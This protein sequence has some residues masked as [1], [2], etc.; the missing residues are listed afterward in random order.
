M[1]SVT[2]NRARRIA[3]V[4]V[5]VIVGLVALAQLWAGVYVDLAWFKEMGQEAVFWTRLTS[6]LAVA[7]VFSVVTFLLLYP[8]LWLARRLAPRAV[9]RPVA[10]SPWAANVEEALSRARSRAE[11]YL[12]RLIPLGA[13]LVS[14]AVGAA[15]GGEW[16][17]FRLA[18]AGQ[19]FGVTDP[20]F[21]RD[22][23]FYVF[24]LPA[25]RMVA[26]WLYSTL[27]LALVATTAVHLLDGAIDI[28]ARV[29]RFA[30]HVKAHLSVLGS[31]ILLTKAL[32]YWVARFELNFSERGQVIGASYTDV[33]AQV[34]A[35]WILM[36]IV[37]VLAALLMLNIRL[38]GWRLPLVA[39]G[40]WVA[41]SFLV[42]GVYP[43]LVQQFR[44]DP[45][46]V[47]FEAPYIERNIAATRAGF[48]LDD[49][50]TQ[51]FPAS[52]DLTAADLREN[53]TTIKN[54]RLWDPEVV[55]SSYKQLQEI[56]T[57]YDF[58]DVDIDRYT[59]DG[60]YREVLV[61]AREM[62]VDELSDRAQTWVNRHL[63]Y[64]HGYGVVVSPVNEV[65][66][67]G[68]PEFIVKDLPPT[69]QTDLV[70]EQPRIYYGE[71]TDEY[72]IAPTDFDEFDYPVGEESATNNYDGAGG[73]P[74][75]SFLS[76]VA[77]ALEFQSSK[78][79]LSEYIRSDSRLLFRR[80]V[81][82]RVSELAPWLAIDS[83]P[84][85]VIVDGRL[86][87]VIDCY[88]TS[89]MYPYSERF[90]GRPGVN[91]VRNSVKAVVD[92]YDGTTTLYAMDEEDPVLAAWREVFPGLVTD[93]DEMPEGLRAHIRY[94]EDLFTLQAEVYKTYHMLDPVVFYNKED[95]WEIPGERSDDP[96]RPYYVLMRLPGEATEEMLLMQPFT[97]RTK[98]NMQS[99]M[100]AR[101]D[102]DEYGSRLVYMFPRQ[103]LVEGPEQ[104]SARINQDPVI[105][106][107]LSLWNQRGSS[108]IFGNMLVIPVETSIVFIQPLYL[109]AEE[110]AIPQLTR[111]I[112][113]YS[114]RL[115]MEP[116]L[117]SALATV[118]GVEGDALTSVGEETEGEDV[119]EGV[120]PA[121]GLAPDIQY[122]DRLYEQAIQ[123]QRDG[124]WAEYGR[125]IEE[126]GRVLD[127]L[128]SQAATAQP[129][130]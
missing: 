62:N 21:G 39:L 46:E 32:D 93:G 95:L 64:T 111:V 69:T 121:G 51:S 124:D 94:P 48:G 52:Q 11:P 54:M 38:Q 31:L 60:E 108:V 78:I 118:F 5:G 120:P 23:G 86:V 9:L 70:V 63:A 22:V 98:Q 58:N 91:Y 67:N 72:V 85:M 19:Q 7:G 82:E 53:E 101:C 106:Q 3:V 65:T 130:R 96:M 119:E 107:Q 113:A 128:A 6:W 36:V 125:L 15:L 99:W 49:V 77:F 84:Y 61:S 105:S 102:G 103:T 71:E 114:D 12:K 73:V 34:P 17:V 97:P 115:A 37:L 56:R 18:L 110:T 126:L 28:R 116:D 55:V 109:Q 44:V 16:P 92:A 100:A 83:D 47:A 90:G 10:D 24:Q 122:A 45:N 8:N 59:I 14:L 87:W 40:V 4:A 66:S 89:D 29:N 127:S 74:L 112:V 43:A 104:I 50:E 25:L 30:P 80:N 76:R 1:A 117:S 2:Q 81:T 75:R 88:T 41:A 20:Q 68:F 33:H 129:A 57:Y 13:A 123:A 35:Y 26:D 27:L 79:L 42:G